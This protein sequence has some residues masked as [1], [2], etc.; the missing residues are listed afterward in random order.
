MVAISPTLGDIVTVHTILMDN[1]RKNDDD[2]DDAYSECS[3]ATENSDDFVHIP[4]KIT[5]KSLMRLHTVNGRYVNHTIIKDSILT[6]CYSHI[7][8]GTGINVIVSGFENGIVRMW[9]SWDLT[10]LREIYV[11]SIDVIG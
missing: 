6:I 11:G 2:D 9:S 4:M 10:M 5:D 1:D 3:E 7:K 8:E